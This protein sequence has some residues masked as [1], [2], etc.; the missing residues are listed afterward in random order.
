MASRLRTVPLDATWLV[1]QSRAPY[2][3]AR[4]HAR[5]LIATVNDV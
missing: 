2:Y 3:A 4:R 1:N 5:R